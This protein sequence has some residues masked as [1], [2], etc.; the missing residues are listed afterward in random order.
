MELQVLEQNEI[1]VA[2]STDHGIKSIVD[3]IRAQVDEKITGMVWDFTK[4]KDRKLVASLAS[5]VAR[6]KTAIDAEGKKL[7]EQY[8]VITSKI[9]AERK[10]ARDM[11]DIER[12][13]IRQPLTDWEDAEK[14][15][16][17]KHEGRILGIK[18]LVETCS[19][20]GSRFIKD[21]IDL[22]M[23]V[24]TNVFEDYEQEAKIAKLETLEALRS[25]LANRE[26][27]E[28]EQAELERLRIAEQAHTQAERDARIAREATEKANREA[29]EKAR[30][31]AEKAQRDKAESEQR[32]ARLLAE[33]EAFILREQAL[34]Q[35][36]V[37][38]AKQ[39][40]INQ[41]QAVEAE[42]LRFEKQQIAKAEAEQRTQELRAADIEHKR[43]INQ[44]ILKELSK[45]GID[46]ETGQNLIAAIY[47]QE[48]PNITIRY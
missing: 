35:K 10:Y 39:A 22:L 1:S 31:E 21:H 17:A 30:F 24:E 42:R 9:D 29:G 48:I 18:I 14:E 33:K 7:K 32:E 13:R 16:K 19:E 26:K 6:S 4:D 3:N 44:A 23:L 5:K 28:A 38:D 8:T 34:K 15:R 2:Y 45:L 20:A 37:D 43:G 27:Y 47:K 40:E 25:L 12:D 41:Q 46:N 36:A 11:L